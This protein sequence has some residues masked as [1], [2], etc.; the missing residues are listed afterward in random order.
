MK[1]FLQHIIATTLALI[2]LLTTFS[3]TVDM[4]YCGDTLVDSA[5]FVKAES[6][7]MEKDFTSPSQSKR[8]NLKKVDCCSDH[9]IIIEGQND[10]KIAY[11]SFNGKQLL[12]I[13]SFVSAYSIQYQ[14]F[15][16]SVIK[17]IDYIPPL[18]KKSIYKLDEVY[19]I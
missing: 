3:F 5:V 13:N 10:L 2:V 12:F 8:C 14:E 7:G 17:C 1:Y 6:C 18:V 9:Q 16:S 11:T 19:L 15:P 4:H